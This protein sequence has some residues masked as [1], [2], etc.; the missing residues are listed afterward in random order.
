LVG[1]RGEYAFPHAAFLEDLDGEVVEID[2]ANV[3]AF[4]AQLVL[5]PLLDL[6][7]R[8][9]VLRRIWVDENGTSLPRPSI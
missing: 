8:K 7:D 2:L 4:L 9:S 5:D 3:D 6:R 1:L